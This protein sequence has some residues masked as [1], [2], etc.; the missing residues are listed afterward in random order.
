M[1]KLLRLRK[2]GIKNIVSSYQKKWEK[3]CYLVSLE[4]LFRIYCL[5]ADSF[6]HLCKDC[7]F[8]SSKEKLMIVLMCSAMLR[9]NA[10]LRQM[11]TKVNF[12][13]E[14]EGIIR[15]WCAC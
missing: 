11:I 6:Q 13:S 10:A 14:F 2:N 15:V 1:M 5:S 8:L 3:C 9:P 12:S 7:Y 4:F